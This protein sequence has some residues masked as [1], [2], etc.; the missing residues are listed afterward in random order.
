MTQTASRAQ[1][2]SFRAPVYE[3]GSGERGFF[4]MTDNVRVGWLSYTSAGE[5]TASWVGATTVSLM[6]CPFDA[7]SCA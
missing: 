2:F 4:A 3:P 7:R 5:S 1:V 6:V